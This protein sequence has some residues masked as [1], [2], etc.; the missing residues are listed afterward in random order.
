MHALFMQ[1]KMCQIILCVCVNCELC[2]R[3]RSRLIILRSTPIDCWKCLITEIKCDAIKIKTKRK[4]SKRFC[5][6]SS[7]NYW[8]AFNCTTTKILTNSS[9]C[10]A[11]INF[12]WGEMRSKEFDVRPLPP[13]IMV[14]RPV[15]V[16]F[17]LP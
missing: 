13:F 1:S 16:A 15:S 6:Y 7:V 8:T 2:G 10:L 11:R 9:F 4:T 17:L 12:V 3:A 14:F 5:Y